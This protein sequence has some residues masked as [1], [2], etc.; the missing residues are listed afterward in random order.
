MSERSIFEFLHNYSG[1]FPVLDS[2]A[3]F[4]ASY[5][6]YL[7]VLLTVFFI[8]RERNWR[9]RFYGSALIVL[10]TVLARGV[11]STIVHYFVGRERP[12]KVLGFTPLING[13]MSTAFP[14]NHAIFFFALGTALFFLNRRWGVWFLVFAAIMGV[15]RVFVGVHWPFDVLAGAIFG[16]ASAFLARV[17]LPP[18][19]AIKQQ[20]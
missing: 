6:P 5:L 3:V 19:E 13:P 16:I 12:F 20:G 17:L 1:K 14:S 7:L 18:R 8:F 11:I 4:F 10:S 9:K 15:A 2:L